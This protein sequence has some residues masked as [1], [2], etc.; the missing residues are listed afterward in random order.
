MQP[1]TTP[2]PVMDVTAPKLPTASPQEV[3]STL[4][5]QATPPPALAVHAAPQG[6]EPD[7]KPD[8]HAAPGH[9]QPAAAKQPSKEVATEKQKPVTQ[10][11]K[12]ASTVPTGTI[13]ATIMVMILLS[14]LAVVV[15]LRT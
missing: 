14:G 7:K 10:K 5:A 1:S 6:D 9:A 11:P 8:A 3:K 13:F 2:K 4:A 12:A 15:Y